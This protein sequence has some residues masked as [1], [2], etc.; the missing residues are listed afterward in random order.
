MET[1]TN[2]TPLNEV[3]LTNLGDLS[4]LFMEKGNASKEQAQCLIDELTC[5]SPKQ[6]LKKN[7]I[8]DDNKEEATNI[9]SWRSKKCTILFNSLFSF[10]TD[11]REITGFKKIKGRLKILDPVTEKFKNLAKETNAE[12][13]KI[14]G[15][16]TRRI[17]LKHMRNLN[18]VWENCFRKALSALNK[19]EPG[20]IPENRDVM[21]STYLNL[22]PEEY[23]LCYEAG[24]KIMTDFKDNNNIPQYSNSIPDKHILKWNKQT[25]SKMIVEIEK[26]RS[27]TPNKEILNIDGTTMDNGQLIDKFISLYDEIHALIINAAYK[28]DNEARTEMDILTPRKRITADIAVQYNRLVTQSFK[29]A[30]SVIRK[31][32]KIGKNDDLIADYLDLK[33]IDEVTPKKNSKNSRKS[34]KVTNHPIEEEVTT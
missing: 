22:Y 3:N 12:A 27:Q 9:N 24:Q 2:Q 6:A 26:I 31:S 28:A 11:I 34:R 7:D 4:K 23:I 16:G 17:A 8:W 10:C 1:I 33:E 18:S 5:M 19:K 30:L 21:V 25:K 14:V 13:R 15:A 32:Y 20:S 29:K